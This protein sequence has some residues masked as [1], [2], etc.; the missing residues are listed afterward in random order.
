MLEQP[1]FRQILVD[2]LQFCFCGIPHFLTDEGA[3]QFNGEQHRNVG[4]EEGIAV[5][6]D[7]EQLCGIFCQRGTCFVLSLIHI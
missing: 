2:E 5:Y 6:A 7:S 4:V 1:H 3:Q